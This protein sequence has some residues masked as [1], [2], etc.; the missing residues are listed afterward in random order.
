MRKKTLKIPE[1]MAELAK[2]VPE[3]NAEYASFIAE[4][5]VQPY[6]PSAVSWQL[7]EFAQIFFEKVAK[8]VEKKAVGEE[9]EANRAFKEFI[10]AIKL[11]YYRYCFRYWP[12]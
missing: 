8:M 12:V 1:T 5:Q 7:L 4:N 3:I 9:V 2:K 10:D 11:F 6:R